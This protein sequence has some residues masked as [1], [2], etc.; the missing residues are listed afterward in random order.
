[1]ISVYI[2][3]TFD[4]GPMDECEDGCDLTLSHNGG[5]YGDGHP[6][7]DQT[8]YATA[9]LEDTMCRALAVVQTAY[10][11]YGGHA[12]TRRYDIL[13]AVG[14]AAGGDGERGPLPGGRVLSIE[15][16]SDHQMRLYGSA[17]LPG[18]PWPNIAD[19]IDAFNRYHGHSDAQT[20]HV[21]TFGEEGVTLF[22]E[23][24]QARS[25]AGHFPHATLTEDMEVFTSE[26]AAELL[27][28]Y[29]C[30]SQKRS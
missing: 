17:E 1:M 7:G 14:I 8:A 16:L 30:G 4:R 26:A 9:S 2:V 18:A 28:E 24:D 3:R 15:T 6:L 29:G 23:V 13:H 27:A 10:E 11:E 21:V 20:V 25:Y 22:E 19:Y 5:C 12:E